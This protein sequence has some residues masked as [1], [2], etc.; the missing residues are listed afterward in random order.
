MSPR[1]VAVAGDKAG[2]GRRS[3]AIMAWA[4]S[5]ALG[6]DAPMGAENRAEAARGVAVALVASIISPIGVMPAMVSLENGNP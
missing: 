3:A 6:P 1:T 4:S 5:G 2:T